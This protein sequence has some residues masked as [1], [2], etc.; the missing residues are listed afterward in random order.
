MT[1]EYRS[2]GATPYQAAF[3]DVSGLRKGDQVRAAGVRV[4]QVTDIDVQ[5]NSTVVV[6]FEVDETLVLNSATTAT[7]EY[8]NLIGD[9]IVQAG[10]HKRE[11]RCRAW[12]RVR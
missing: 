9:R 11:G 3:D 10:H 6:T 7:I 5:P 1:S 8:R 4:G 12:P 2:G